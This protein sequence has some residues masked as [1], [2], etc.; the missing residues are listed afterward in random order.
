VKNFVSKGFLSVVSLLYSMQCV[1][2]TSWETGT[3]E[4]AGATVQYRTI[5]K[6]QPLMLINGGPGYSSRHFTGIAE[7]LSKNYRVILFDQRGT[8]ASTVRAYDSANVNV[9]L[10]LSDMSVLIGQL[11]YESVSVLGH[12]FGGILAMSFAEKYP[13]RITKLILSASAGINLDFVSYFPD[14]IAQRLPTSSSRISQVLAAAQTFKERQEAFYAAISNNV[15]AYLFDKEKV[16]EL[17]AALT[18]P[19]SYNPDFNLLLWS[20][21]FSKH[22]DLSQKLGK[23]TKPTLVIQGRQD[24]LGDETAIRIHE[25]IK[26]SK[27]VFLNKCGHVAWLDQPEAFLKELDT[28]LLGLP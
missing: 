12:S 13:Q 17:R 2:Q 7:T 22:Y 21:L 14:N 5:G 6:G 16:P 1:A 9:D 10:I 3:I 25:A 15:P 28:F 27:L 19:G 18:R 4:N 8:G 23:F 20:D 11:G 26:Q 24:I